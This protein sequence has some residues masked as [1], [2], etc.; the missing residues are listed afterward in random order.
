MEVTISHKVLHWTPEETRAE[1][2]QLVGEAPLSI[3]VQ[4]LPFSVGMRTPGQEREQAAG[5]LLFRGIVTAKADIADIRWTPE[6]PDEVRVALTD[7]RWA[8]VAEFVEQGGFREVEFGRSWKEA[9]DAV[10]GTVGPFPR[11]DGANIDAAEGFARLD[12]LSE[13]QTLRKITRTTHATAIY[14]ESFDRMAVCEDV[15]RHNGMD[16]AIGAL[17][18]DGRL[19]KAGVMVLSSR[20]SFELVIKAARA[21]IP[22]I[23]SMSLPSALAVKLGERLNMT[24][25]SLSKKGGGEIF[26]DPGRLNLS[27]GGPASGSQP[28]KKKPGES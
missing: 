1:E 23:F 7:D 24:L 27:W 6:T 22:T 4:D 19:E 20:I 28:E 9:I 12:E 3:C 2:R 17:L 26:C 5:F 11:P 14:T 15:G 10:C 13:H 25:A 8:M 16:K 18:L 21:G